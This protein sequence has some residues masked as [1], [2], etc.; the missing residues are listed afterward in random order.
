MDMDIEVKEDVDDKD[1]LGIERDDREDRDRRDRDDHKM[2]DRDS[3]DRDRDR[4]DRDRSDRDRRD[5][6][7]GDRDR[8]RDRD[9]DSGKV[10]SNQKS[11]P[12]IDSFLGRSSRRGGGGDHWEPE[13]RRSR[14]DNDVSVFIGISLFFIDL[15]KFNSVVNA[16]GP[17]LAA[18]RELAAQLLPV[19]VPDARIRAAGAALVPHDAETVKKETAAKVVLEAETAQ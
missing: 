8:E 9:R 6:D 18:V 13:S 17:A 5:R 12:I 14:G 7:R 10:K 3:R 11:E 4:R 1:M 19:V 15:E 16:P 2:D